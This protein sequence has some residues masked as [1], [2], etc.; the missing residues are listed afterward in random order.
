MARTAPVSIRL[1]TELQTELERMSDETGIPMSTLMRMAIEAA[2]KAYRENGG[3]IEIP[4]RFTAI[5][6]PYPDTGDPPSQMVAE[7]RS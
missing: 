5:S 2:V 3:R 4:L 1:D 7:E 6:L